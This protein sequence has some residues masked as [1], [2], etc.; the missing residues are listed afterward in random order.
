MDIFDKITDKKIDIFDRIA[1]GGDIFDDI[2]PGEQAGL[3]K[4]VPALAK[5]MMSQMMGLDRP[6]PEPF[7]Q[8]HPTLY[9]AGKTAM[10]MPGLV[11]KAAMSVVSGA[12]FS[13][14]ERVEEAGEW[15]SRKLFGEGRKGGATGTWTEKPQLHPYVEKAGKFAGSMI[16]ISTAGKAVAAPIINTVMKHRYL[17]P[18]A[19]MIGWGAAGA[20]YQAGERMLGEGELPTPQEL[21]KHGL[22]WAG[23]EGVF[24]SLG[25]TGQLAIGLNRLS[26]TWTIPKKEVLKI[27][28]KEAKTRGMPLAKYIYAK[29]GV[30]K[31]L[32]VKEKA[33]AKEFLDMVDDLVVPFKKKGTYQSLVK[34]LET[35]SIEGRIKSFR[36]HVGETIVLG[37]KTKPGT[38]I[39]KKTGDIEKALLKPGFRRSAEDVALI[40]SIKTDIKLPIQKVAPRPSHADLGAPSQVFPQAAK[41]VTPV[42]KPKPT[43]RIDM[44]KM[45]KTRGK[46]LTEDL[47][48][49]IQ[50]VGDD[51]RY[52]TPVSKALQKK[53]H[54]FF[55]A[56][57]KPGGI[58]KP[59]TPKVSSRPET[60]KAK[61]AALKFPDGTIITG[62]T[63]A[64]AYQ[65]AL[66]KGLEKQLDKGFEEGFVTTSNKFITRDQAQVLYKAN[67]TNA[68]LKK[69]VIETQTK[70]LP[71]TIRGEVKGYPGYAKVTVVGEKG[72]T[73][74]FGPTGELQNI[75]EKLMAGR[76]HKPLKKK[77]GDAIPRTISPDTKIIMTALKKIKPLSTKQKEIYSIERGKRLTEAIKL[78]GTTSGERGYHTEL[79]A[80][81]GPMEHLEFEPIRKLVTQKTVN[82]LMNEI[83]DCP[84]LSNWETYPAR[85]ALA[86]ILQ[87]S[88]PTEG[89]QTLLRD[90]FG[91]K[92]VDELAR[93]KAL[94]LRVK[95]AGIMAVNFPKAIKSSYDLSAP[96]RQGVFLL[97]RYKQWLPAFRDMFKYFGSKEAYHEGALGIRRHHNYKLAKEHKLALTDLG[98]IT[99]REEAFMSS[100]AEKIPGVG[101]SAR[102]YTGF[103]NQLRFDVFNDFVKKGQQLGL[104][105]NEKYLKA[106]TKYINHATGR[107]HL[108]GLE[109]AATELNAVFFSPRLIMSRLQLINPVFY[110]KLEKHVRKEA[111]KDLFAFTGLTCSV[112][113]LAKMAGL[114]VETDPRSAD[115]MKIKV[116][117]KRFDTLGGLQQT[118][119]TVAQFT[120]GEV[121]STT[122]GKTLTLGEG[123]KP[124]TRLGVAGRFLQYKLAPVSSFAVTL[125]TGQAT[126]GGKLDVPTEIG[127]LF[128]PMAAQ[129]MYELYD[130]EGL[131]AIPL[132]VPAFFGV[133]LQTY[134]GVSTYGLSGKDYRALNTE[135]SRL[136]TSL[137][138]PSTSVYGQEL[139]NKE[140]KVFKNKAG[141]EIARSVENIMKA[142]FYKKTDDD[143]KR[144]IIDKVIDHTKEKVRRELF[145]KYMFV[146]QRA[147]AIRK[148][149]YKPVQE[150]RKMAKEQVSK[151]MK[152]K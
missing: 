131:S 23:I 37:E 41:V 120:A 10:D 76:L 9:A 20:T 102:A 141:K 89:G 19:R 132:A 40:K 45:G 100:W 129:D 33:A 126:M 78:R 58:A 84:I 7:K 88:M 147:T 77:V 145:R 51:T 109:G 135:L 12:T 48:D 22:V 85:K 27:V 90:V 148:A 5:D 98:S 26:K 18:F 107:G 118:V 82:N 74:G 34:Q 54:D 64:V 96:L 105:K 140:Y 1:G 103:L 94:W 16:A 8:V 42:P 59:I 50:K 4:P 134:G 38:I 46:I 49:W 143:G 31:A 86:Q 13:L 60:I 122:T 152:G 92:F 11:E 117:N 17:A 108:M 81:K 63:H 150:S 116:G 136:K 130:D 24:S 139:T 71:K 104:L 128:A 124:M 127:R 142:S 75:Y 93:N 29:A 3:T 67:E 144:H 87:G 65:K 101:A 110:V 15:L 57:Q 73:L 47:P 133:G 43:Q 53:Y 55:L 137:G 91:K 83:R 32:G 62:Q 69:G 56:R 39:T 114:D 111:L 106:A 123:Y 28:T 61:G 30:Q 21:V 36:A 115:F 80:L 112:G 79:K 95:E 35:E 146:Q 119:R 72:V 99:S 25:W 151:L 66:N 121:I 125:L 2:A 6:K 70:I 14:P 44:L 68:L 149:T 97:R 138:F 52:G 113:A